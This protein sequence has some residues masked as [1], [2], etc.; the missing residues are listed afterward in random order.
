MLMNAIFTVLCF[1]LRDIGKLFNWDYQTTSVYI[2]I[3]LWPLLCVIMSLTMLGC[4]C[5]TGNGLWITACT[6]YALLNG[7]A[8][9][10]IIRHYYPASIQD[11]FQL[12]WAELNVIASRWHT[13]Y[14]IVNLLIYVVLFAVIM[15]FDLMLILLMR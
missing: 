11:I 1:L 2:C 6:L 15:T 13:T 8:Y 12:C 5:A 7:A 14:A 10:A 9:F 4:A 3:H